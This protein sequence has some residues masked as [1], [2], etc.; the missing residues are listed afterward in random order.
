MATDLP[1]VGD[2]R[3]RPPAAA[4]LRDQRFL[5]SRQYDPNVAVKEARESKLSQRFANYWNNDMRG[6]MNDEGERRFASGEYGGARMTLTNTDGSLR[7]G[8]GM[9]N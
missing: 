1:N 5:K 8:K 2:E 7:R 9:P 4:R 6:M 3:V